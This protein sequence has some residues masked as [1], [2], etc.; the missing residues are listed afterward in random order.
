MSW[1]ASA[2]MQPREHAGREAGVVGSRGDADDPGRPDETTETGVARH[3]VERGVERRLRNG[4]PA[5][6]G[7]VG[8]ELSVAGAERQGREKGQTEENG[9][10]AHALSIVRAARGVSQPDHARCGAGAPTGASAPRSATRSVASL[11]PQPAAR[12]AAG[13]PLSGSPGARAGQAGHVPRRAGGGARRGRRPR[14]GVRADGA[15][16]RGDGGHLAS[17]RVRTHS[18]RGARPRGA[19]PPGAA[20]GRS[21]RATRR[22]C[23]PP[24]P[25]PARQR[26]G[27]RPRGGGPPGRRSRRQVGIERQVEL[28]LRGLWRGSSPFSS[29]TA[30]ATMRT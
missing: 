29:A 27:G 15:G 4:D 17:R 8:R 7:R 18:A 14:R 24:R 13:G 1:M 10:P 25:G 26:A 21:G 11:E 19:P 9:D 3:R 6:P 28:D 16:P 20:A 23:R 12:R 30:S 2:W 22:R 5:H